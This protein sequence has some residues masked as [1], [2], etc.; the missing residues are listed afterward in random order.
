VRPLQAVQAVLTQYDAVLQCLDELEAPES[1]LTARASGLQ[2]PLN[3][4]A[5]LMALEMALRVF[6]RL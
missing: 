4:G 1:Q 2:H 6:G 5:M 3:Q